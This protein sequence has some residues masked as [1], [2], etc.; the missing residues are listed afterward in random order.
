MNTAECQFEPTTIYE[1]KSFE[2]NKKSVRELVSDAT[3]QLIQTQVLHVINS[4]ICVSADHLHT[5]KTIQLSIFCNSF[6][7][8]HQIVLHYQ[9]FTLCSVLCF[10]GSLVKDSC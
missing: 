5:F 3:H 10:C 2:A 8:L 7:S 1:M 6:D 4:A 9:T